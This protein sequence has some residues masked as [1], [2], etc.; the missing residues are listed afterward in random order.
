MSEEK[1]KNCKYCKRL[2]VPVLPCYDHAR[3]VRDRYVC[4]AMDDCVMYLGD[5]ESWC[6]MFEEVTDGK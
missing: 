2:Y 4:T 6:E 1:C 3:N 5:D